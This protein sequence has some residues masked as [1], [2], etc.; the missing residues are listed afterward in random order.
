LTL[1]THSRPGAFVDRPLASS[2]RIL[3]AFALVVYAASTE[4]PRLLVPAMWLA[5][6]MLSLNGTGIV[7]AVWCL[8]G[9]TA[10]LGRRPRAERAGPQLEA[11]LDAIPVD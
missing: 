11:P 2:G 1:L 8:R 3:G 10:R 4:R 9:Q 5:T 7:V 6:P